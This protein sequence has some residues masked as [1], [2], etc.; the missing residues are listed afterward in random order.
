MTFSEAINELK[1]GIKITRDIWVEGAYLD[2]ATGFSYTDM[3]GNTIPCNLVGLST[4]QNFVYIATDG[5]M[6]GWTASQSD[7]M[8]ED[9]KV[10]KPADSTTSDSAE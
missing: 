2:V 5:I 9:W 7:M 3:A 1:K 10:Y 4:S 8:A 6:L